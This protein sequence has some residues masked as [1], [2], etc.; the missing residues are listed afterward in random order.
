MQY[1]EAG[2]RICGLVF[3]LLGDD[4]KVELGEFDA[5]VYELTFAVGTVKNPFQ[6]VVVGAYYE[7]GSS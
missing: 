4:I 1:I 3:F 2:E 5:P 6:R 7:S